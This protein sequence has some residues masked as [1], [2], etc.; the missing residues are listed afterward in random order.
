MDR[1][2]I[3]TDHAGESRWKVISPNNEIVAASSAGFEDDEGARRNLIR[4]G[5]GELV[6]EATAAGED[7]GS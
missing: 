3:Y 1:A 7:S 6:G 5:H 4:C 2:L